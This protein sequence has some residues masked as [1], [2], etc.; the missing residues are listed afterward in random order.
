MLDRKT[1]LFL[2]LLLLALIGA[3]FLFGKRLDQ[4]IVDREKQQETKYGLLNMRNIIQGSYMS[5]CKQPPPNELG[6]RALWESG[7]VKGWNGPYMKC[8]EFTI[9]DSW[10]T[11]LMYSSTATRFELRSAGLD[12]IFGTN[13]DLTVES[14]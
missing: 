5:D 3:Y 13:D 8:K 1:R 4:I 2:E 14:Q 11:P 12:T 9:R 7:W 6:F 10:G